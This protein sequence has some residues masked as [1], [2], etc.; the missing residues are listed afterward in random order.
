MT[1]SLLL[2]PL[3]LFFFFES[4]SV[5]LRYETLGPASLLVTRFHIPKQ[6]NH[7]DVGMT[8]SHIYEW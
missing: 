1:T 7:C 5:H 8:T 3:V 4:I 6:A 2:H